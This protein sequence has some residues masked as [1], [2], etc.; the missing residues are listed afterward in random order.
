[1][2]EAR[3]QTNEWTA[4]TKANTGSNFRDEINLKTPDIEI[5]VPIPSLI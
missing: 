1:M 3:V 5:N 4:L 2:V